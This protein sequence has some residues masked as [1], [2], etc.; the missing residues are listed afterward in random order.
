MP[1]LYICWRNWGK[2]KFVKKNQTR[3]IQFQA[4]VTYTIIYL[5][6]V[7]MCSGKTQDLEEE[8]PSVEQELRKLMEKPGESLGGNTFKTRQK[9]KPMRLKCVC[10]W[11]EHLKTAW[12]R[13]REEQLMDKLVEIV[14]DRNAIIEGLDEDR[15]RCVYKY[16]R[17]EES[18]TAGMAMWF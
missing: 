10:V 13:K 8:Q 6:V 9:M 2:T 3:D 11:A 5:N 12:D 4:V 1:E 7:F 17:G 15:L 18:P 16:S 14:N